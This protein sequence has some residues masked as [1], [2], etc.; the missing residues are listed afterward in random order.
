M[1]QNIFSF[2][3]FKQ[4]KIMEMQELLSQ[5]SE[6]EKK[7]EYDFWYSAKMES[8]CGKMELIFGYKPQKRY[9]K[10]KAYT[11]CCDK[12]DKPSENFNDFV[13]VGS[14]TFADVT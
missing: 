4:I 1:I 3:K 7:Q 2:K 9:F 14:G 10:G 5:I 11:E 8:H 13:F 12:G 6:L